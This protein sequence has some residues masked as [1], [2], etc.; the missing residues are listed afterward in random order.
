M[1]SFYMHTVTCMNKRKQF[2]QNKQQKTIK[3]V[4]KQKVKGRRQQWEGER[5]G[6][7][8]Y[9]EESWGNEE[10]KTKYSR[11]LETT[12]Y[13]DYVLAKQG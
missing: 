1:M 7:W 12:I 2:M 6:R 10:N 9:S 3:S 11:K 8:I 13:P 4:I 5:T